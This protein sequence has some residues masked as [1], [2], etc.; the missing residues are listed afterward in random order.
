VT[1]NPK[2]PPLG[3]GWFQSEEPTRLGLVFEL[4]RIAL[5]FRVRPLPVLLL[6]AL[7]TGGVAFKFLNKPKLYEADVVL[8]L[9]EGSDSPTKTGIPFD[10]LKAYIATVLMPEAKLLKLIEDRNL[11][12]LRRT[13]GPQWAVGELWGQIEIEIWKNSFLYYDPEA[14]RSLQ[15]SAR[16]GITVVDGDPERALLLVR[17]VAS[18]IIQTHEEKR[19]EIAAALASKVAMI[20]EGLTKQLH[21]LSESLS[22]KQSALALATKEGDARLAAA[23]YT[24]ISDL[25]RQEKAAEDQL[26]LIRKSPEAVADQVT[27]AGLGIQLDI[28]EERRPDRPEQSWLSLAVTLIIIGSGALFGSAL[29][30]GAFD[31]R[32]HDTDDVARLNMLVLGHVPGFPGDRVGSLRS[33]GALRARVPWYLRWRSRP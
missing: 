31:P 30:L 33:R 25:A 8:A 14:D 16:I 15:K 29:L 23:L 13:L 21:E 17:D 12:R 1:R 27:A 9:T 6:A 2:P 20:R 7:M 10:Q 22:V 3:D 24:E 19:R 26:A 32:V 28:V 4:R 5:R 18:I 11:Y